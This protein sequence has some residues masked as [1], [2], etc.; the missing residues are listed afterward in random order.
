MRTASIVAA[1]AVA[2]AATATA[3]SAFSAA[4]VSPAAA[5]EGAAAST[6]AAGR[7]A[8]PEF[9]VD[10]NRDPQLFFRIDTFTVP[11]SARDEFEAAMHRNMGFIRTLPGFRGHLVFE[12]REGASPYDIVTVAAW[13]SREAVERA[14]KEVRAYYQRIGFDMPASL[15]RWG[16]TLVRA[17]YEAPGR[18]Q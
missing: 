8:V 15:K 11:A 4:V 12:K 17:D 6:P 7:T 3:A 18:L 10:L 14:G 5:P 1:L 2:A 13:E 9:A 16:V